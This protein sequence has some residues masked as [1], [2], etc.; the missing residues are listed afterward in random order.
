MRRRNTKENE[1]RRMMACIGAVFAL[2]AIGAILLF[3]LAPF[4]VNLRADY[5]QLEGELRIED[6]YGQEV[7]VQ[8]VVDRSIA[9]GET[10]RSAP[11]STARIE[12]VEGS[13]AFAY[14]LGDAEW[15]LVSAWRD[16]TALNHILN[17]GES[18]RIVISQTKG[19][20]V[21]DFSHAKPSRDKLNLLIRFPDSEIAPASNCFQATVG[22]PSQVVEVPCQIDV[23]LTPEP[24]LQP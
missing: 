3:V 1:I 5:D 6:S 23:I 17:N 13:N 8:S 11:D 10:V 2:V 15:T 21:Y 16:A 19:T 18:Y 12:I 24:T 20:V 22:T 4:R 9:A 14:L 7:A